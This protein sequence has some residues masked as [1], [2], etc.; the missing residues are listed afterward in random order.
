M[1]DKSYIWIPFATPQKMEE[2]GMPGEIEIEF[3]LA[4]RYNQQD[5]EG[6]FIEFLM[7]TGSV[8][9]HDEVVIHDCP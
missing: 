8:K 1:K 3:A 9:S 2:L 6:Y 5:D 4:W 7:E